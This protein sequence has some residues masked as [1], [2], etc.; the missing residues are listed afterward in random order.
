MTQGGCATGKQLAAALAMGA[1]GMNM[2]TAFMA[3][4]E[5]PIHA[6]IKKASVL[7]PKHCIH[8]HFLSNRGPCFGG[9]SP[10]CNELRGTPTRVRSKLVASY[11]CHPML[12]KK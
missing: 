8:Q 1:E 5:S 3:T 4:V 6:G 11:T 7:V 12:T 2:G 9:A 10:S